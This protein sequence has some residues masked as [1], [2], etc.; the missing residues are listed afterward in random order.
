MWNE[1]FCSKKKGRKMRIPINRNYMLEFYDLVFLPFL[2]VVCLTEP[3]NICSILHYFKLRK[4]QDKKNYFRE[5]F[6]MFIYDIL[7]ICITILLLSSATDT[8]PCILLIIRTLKK[9]IKRDSDS[10]AVYEA[11]YN[12]DF[13]V[14]VRLLYYKN[15]KKKFNIFFFFLDFLLITRTKQLYKRTKPFI[16]EFFITQKLIVLNFLDKLGLFILRGG[17]SSTNLIIEKINKKK[18]ANLHNLPPMLIISICG[19]LDVKSITNLT[20]TSRSLAVK[21]SSNILWNQIYEEIYKKKLKK[22]LPNSQFILFSPERY[23]N[24]KETCHQ[25]TLLILQKD[26]LK[27]NEMRDRIIGFYRVVEEETL[28]SIIRIPNLLLVF[29]WKITGYIFYILNDWID[30]CYKILENSQIVHNYL[31][32]PIKYSFVDLKKY[33][34]YNTIQMVSILGIFNL[35]F[36]IIKITSIFLINFFLIFIKTICFTNLQNENII[37]GLNIRTRIRNL[38]KKSLFFQ[39]IYLGFYIILHNI[40]SVLPSFYYVYQINHQIPLL[41]LYPF[42]FQTIIENISRLVLFFWES[43]IIVKFQ[44]VFGKFGLNVLFYY[45]NFEIVRYMSTMLERTQIIIY[46]LIFSIFKQDPFLTFI[47]IIIFPLTSFFSYLKCIS[48]IVSHKYSHS[49]TIV[50]KIFV[51]LAIT[52]FVIW[53][54]TNKDF[55]LSFAIMIYGSMNLMVIRIINERDYLEN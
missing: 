39:M 31:V 15:L 46:N 37:H 40:L 4:Y 6:C 47:V 27:A 16:Q 12:Y 3:W 50:Q 20:L 30:T 28:E 45:L 49:I 21:T 43:R 22:T 42:T 13:K 54:Y 29:P 8:Y 44:I 7:T 53:F 41:N 52:P 18:L 14:E 26:V 17:A 24:Y 5:I 11:N 2:L 35:L 34:S 23:D 33:D 1:L 48:G 55:F 32:I 38:P 10:I 19:Y 25:A 51:V 36:I 9:N